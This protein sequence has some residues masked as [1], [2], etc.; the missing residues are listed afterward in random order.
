MINVQNVIE[1]SKNLTKLIF[2][3][4]CGFI[5]ILSMYLKE[6]PLH[7]NYYYHKNIIKAILKIYRQDQISQ[8]CQIFYLK[9]H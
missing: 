9:F 2:I 7:F 6:A 5:N 8:K 4:N 1:C 3:L